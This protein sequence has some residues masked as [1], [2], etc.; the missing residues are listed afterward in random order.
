[1]LYELQNLYFP[2]KS[3]LQL[4]E[5]RGRKKSGRKDNYEPYTIQKI[6]STTNI[7]SHKFG[8]GFLCHVFPSASN[9]ETH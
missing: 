1:M 3:T 8:T 2:T 7:S 4:I 6:A 5:I 9:I